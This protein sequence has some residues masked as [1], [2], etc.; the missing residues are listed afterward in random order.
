MIIAVNARTL[1]ALPGDGIG[2]FTFET[3]RRMAL[4]HPEHHFIMICDRRHESIPVDLPN[5]EYV[6][7]SPRNFHPVVWWLWH[8]K[9]LPPLLRKL[10][11][12]IFV[13]PDGII[14]LKTDVP[15]LS[16]IHDLNHVHRP[17]DIPLIAG[18]YYRYFFPR[19]ADKAVRIATVSVF[20]AG[21]ISV[22]YGIDPEK[23]DVVNNGVAELFSPPA[24]DE[25]GETRREFTGGRPYFLFVGN[26]SPRK[27]VETLID[28]YNIFRRDSGAGHMLVL[29]G[30][31]L[32]L[33]GAMRKAVSSS[34][35][36]D[37]IIFTGA[38]CRDVLRRLYGAAEA[39][40]F[41]PWFEGFG[42]PVV[43]A[44]RC[45]TPCILS[46][47]SS[48]PEVSGGAALSAGPAGAEA[49]ASAMALLV[50]DEALRR[51]LSH[52]GY[53]NSLRY[54]WDN[55]AEALWNSIMKATLPQP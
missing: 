50:S 55:T 25:A 52:Q 6:L 11:P 16:V 44:M 9:L 35:Y 48:L 34:P 22:T 42:I 12:D 10:R 14:P 19:I 53:Q 51:R 5:I 54:S 38:V 36:G 1:K 24:G 40:T 32:Y 39:F 23:I 41:V 20:S 15:C 3:I 4:V 31:S 17:E 28:A 33:T 49:I 7:L 2:W 27:N 13:A 30:S 18:S 43:E 26:F 8:E 21:D 29:T 47:T 45:G 37:D 46:D